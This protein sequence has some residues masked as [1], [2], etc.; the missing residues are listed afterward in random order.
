MP[1]RNGAQL[2]AGLK[3]NR[4]IWVGNGRVRDIASHPAFAGAAKGLAEVF[5]LQ[6]QAAEECLTPDEET[7]EPINVSHIF[8]RSIADLKARHR[9]LARIA[10]HSVGFMGR[11]PDYMN[12]TYAGFAACA[13]EWAEHGNEAGAARL[14][15]YQKFLRRQDICLTHTLI[16]PT[17]DKSKGDSPRPDSDV[18]LHK[19]ADTANGIIVRGARV[20]ATLAPF[21]DEIAVYPSLPLGEGAEKFALS[22][23]IPMATPGLIFLCRDSAAGS[24]NRFDHP[25]SARFD[26][27]D[28]F[29]IFDDVEVP[30]DRLFIDGNLKVYNQVM[31]RSWSPNVMQQTMVRAQTKLEFA[32]GLAC[33]LAEAIGDR[34]PNT[35][36]MLGEIWSYAE[37]TRAAIETAEAEARDFGNGIVFP[38]GR[39]SWA[40]RAIMPFWMPRVNEIIRTIGSHNLL[41]TPSHAMLNDAELRP[42]INKYLRGAEDMDAERRARLFRLAWDFTGTALAGRVEL[43]ERFYLTSGPRNQMRAQ[44]NADRTRAAALLGR[45]LMET[46]D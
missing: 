27:Q 31:T 20:L 42:L 40:L 10:E 34:S 28:A 33:A 44:A 30:R 21:A 7:G 23:C 9:G 16:H 24:A 15:E 38:S 6:L 3:D 14:V 13:H 22:F 12:V 4:A 2:L 37:L 11:T 45:F 17:T 8:P 46:L 18:P 29:V 35:L 43:Y 32:W 25:L 36:S 1:A 26:E 39:P 19:V 41:A 5:D